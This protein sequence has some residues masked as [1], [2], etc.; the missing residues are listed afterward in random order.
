MIALITLQSESRPRSIGRRFV[1]AIVALL[2]VL[3]AIPQAVYA[4]KIWERIQ[5][6]ERRDMAMAQAI[7]ADVRSHSLQRPDL[8]A[9]RFQLFGTTERNQSFPHWSSVGESAF[10]QSWSITGIFRQLLGLEVTHIAYRSEGNE[11]EV[12]SSLPA[13]RAWPAADSIVAYRGLWLVC[14]EDNPAPPKEGGDR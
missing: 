14:L 11:N 3:Y 12:R 9:D 6:L 5:L 2:I 13:C 7:A 4:G 10:R 1:G 8:P